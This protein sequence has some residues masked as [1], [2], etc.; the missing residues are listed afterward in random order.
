MKNLTLT[1]PKAFLF[2]HDGV[3]VSSEDLHFMAWKKLFF[4]LRMDESKILLHEL[5]GRSAPEILKYILDMQRPGWSTADF[6]LDQLAYQKNNYYL[7]FAKNSLAAY[8]GVIPSLKKIRAL[9]IQTAIVSNA[10][11]RELDYSMDRLG[12]RPL[13]DAHFSR[14]EL[15]APKPDFRAYLTAAKALGREPQECLGVEDSTTGLKALQNSGIGSIAIL[16][17]YA[18][19]ELEPYNPLGFYASILEMLEQGFGVQVP[20]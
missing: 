7:E 11:R 14:D 18:R 2:D 19:K 16:T 15:P 20:L 17:N 1:L 6:N 10:K 4:D 5:V 13:F 9:G 12:L 8:P 3:L